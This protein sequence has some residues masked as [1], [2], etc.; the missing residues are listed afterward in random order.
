MW[1]EVEYWRNTTKDKSPIEM[2]APRAL[3][4]SNHPARVH[5]EG[6]GIRD[7]NKQSCHN[8]VYLQSATSCHELPTSSPRGQTMTL[9]MRM[10]NTDRLMCAFEG[11]LEHVGHCAYECK[12]DT[13]AGTHAHTQNR[14]NKMVMSARI[15]KVFSRTRISC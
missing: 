3:E 5:H 14:D 10:A 15:L 1:C 12:P 9:I 11:C 2:S 6:Q 13:H 4:I 8:K 7:K